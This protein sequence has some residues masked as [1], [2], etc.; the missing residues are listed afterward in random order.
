MLWGP[1]AA[2]SFRAL[3][4]ARHIPLRPAMAHTARVLVYADHGAPTLSIVVAAAAAATPTVMNREAT[5]PV[6]GTLARLGKK[7]GAD[8]VLLAGDGA[9]VP[10]D[11][12]NERAWV[13]GHALRLGD[14]EPLPLVINAPRLKN[15][16]LHGHPLVGCPLAPV[17]DAEY[18]ASTEHFQYQWF[19]HRPDP[20]AAPEPVAQSPSVCRNKK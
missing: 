15:V 19:R 7:L 12:P 8:C 20:A 2:A 1:A 10:G 16:Q 5:A 11:T 6:D 17:V 4:A 14:G 3:L 9:P 18:V 13:A